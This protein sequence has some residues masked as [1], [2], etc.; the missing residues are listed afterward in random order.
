MSLDVWLTVGDDC[1]W[2]RNITHNVNKIAMEICAYECLWRPDEIGVVYAKDNIKDLESALLALNR[3]Y[4]KLDALNP[5]NGWGTLDGLIEFV[6]D[7]LRWCYRYPDAK[8][9]VDR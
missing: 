6:M 1:V 5:P 4:D 3:M 9:N 2:S 8:I 7:Y